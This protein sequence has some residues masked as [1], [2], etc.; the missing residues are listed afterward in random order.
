MRLNVRLC[1][2][3]TNSKRHSNRNH[4]LFSFSID[5]CG[6]C[7]TLSIKC[8]ETEFEWLLRHHLTFSLFRCARLALHFWSSPIVFFLSNAHQ[9]IEQ[10]TERNA[11]VWRHRQIINGWSISISKINHLDMANGF[12]QVQKGQANKANKKKLTFFL[13]FGYCLMQVAQ[14]IGTPLIFFFGFFHLLGYTWLSLG[15]H[16][17]K[18]CDSFLFHCGHELQECRKSNTNG[19]YTTKTRVSL[20]LCC[21][22]FSPSSLHSFQWMSIL[23]QR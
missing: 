11:Q 6:K 9:T 7:V 14:W 2:H 5:S 13:S 22:F 16:F 20:W 10:W 4:K 19:F 3:E 21:T 1:E 8:K 17:D 18:P 23:I 12:V 15:Y